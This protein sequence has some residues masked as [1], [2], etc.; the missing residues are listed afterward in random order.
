MAVNFANVDEIGTPCSLGQ[1]APTD[2][3][4][5][6]APS[7]LIPASLIVLSRIS[8]MSRPAGR[9]NCALNSKRRTAAFCHHLLSVLV[10]PSGLLFFCLSSS[11]R[12]VLLTF[13]A[14]LATRG[15]VA[16]VA[17]LFAGCRRLISLP[18]SETHS[19]GV[20]FSSAGPVR[21]LSVRACAP[22]CMCASCVCLLARASPSRWPRHSGIAS[23]RGALCDGSLCECIVRVP[24]PPSH[25]THF[26]PFPSGAGRIE[27]HLTCAVLF[28]MPPAPRRFLRIL[29]RRRSYEYA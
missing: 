12:H 9:R 23:T 18:P 4:A 27:A 5:T 16:V 15:R 26:S 11:F 19:V 25:L 10:P 20:R 29:S 1:V 28:G 8:R 17:A 22:A 14:R 3:C 7:F 24:L 13:P 6:A 2:A 21:A